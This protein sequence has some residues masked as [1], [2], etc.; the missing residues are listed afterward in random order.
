M[1]S[2]QLGAHEDAWP[3]GNVSKVR[4]ATGEFYGLTVPNLIF[5][6]WFYF[7]LTLSF[8]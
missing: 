6:T 8:D 1:V 5:Y 7:G 3:I 4:L 2:E